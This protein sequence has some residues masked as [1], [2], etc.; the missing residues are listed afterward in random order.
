MKKIFLITTLF[1]ITFFAEKNYIHAAELNCSMADY[2]NRC[3][4]LNYASGKSIELYYKGSDT[5]IVDSMAPLNDRDRKTNYFFYNQNNSF[6]EKVYY[7]NGWYQSKEE[8]CKKVSSFSSSTGGASYKQNKIGI[9]KTAD[10]CPSV[11][12]ETVWK[13]TT[14]R[15]NAGNYFYRI[16]ST[17]YQDLESVPDKNDGYID[18]QTTYEII[19]DEKKDKEEDLPRDPEPDP[20]PKCSD[21][22]DDDLRKY[23]NDIMIYIKIGI[24]ILLIGLIIY[25]L[26]TAV[27][28]GNED[29]IK[30]ARERAIKRIIIAIVIFFVPTLINF[31]FNV[32]NDIWQKKFEICGLDTEK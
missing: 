31:V 21:L 23:I 14:F 11:I 15:W 8:T 30:K 22:I 28:A 4:Y 2:E 20:E 7:V 26:S 5:W 12:Y 25:D 32:V 29:K 19:I 3:V 13:D 18:S 17:K 9:D 6:D 10:G 1:I 27:F 24:P 16:Y